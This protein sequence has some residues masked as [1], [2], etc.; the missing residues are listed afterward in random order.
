[1]RTETTTVYRFSELSE[2]AQQRAVEK[3]AET[4]DTDAWEAEWQDS[5]KCAQEVLSGLGLSWKVSDWNVSP[6]RPSGVYACVDCDPDD[7]TEDGRGWYT[8]DKPLRGVRLWKWLHA[9]GWAKA[10][11]KDC[12]FTGYCAD[13][14]FLAP[15][16]EFMRR[17]H[18]NIGIDDLL[19][20]CAESWA[21]AWADDI[22]YQA[23]E[24]CA[25]QYL[26]DYDPEDFTEDGGIY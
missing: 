24:E 5:L 18:R 11:A 13:E 16:R 12:P 25:R 1:M 22:E 26:T 7:L 2:E 20:D 19:T 8:G 17:P 15:L 14:A 4:A 10:I 3:H 9:N 23:S 21:R 6:W